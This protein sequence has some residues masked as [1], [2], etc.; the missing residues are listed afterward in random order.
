MNNQAL[1]KFLVENSIIIPTADLYGGFSG[2]QDY[3]ILGCKIKNN[4]IRIWKDILLDNNI[5]EIDT[6][7]VN[8]YDVLKASG[9]V[10]QFTDKVIFDK[11]HKCFRADHYA[12]NYFKKHNMT[13]LYA[14]VD[15]LTKQELQDLMNQ[16]KMFESDVEINDEQLMFQLKANTHHGDF[17]RPE[18]A[19][20]IIINYRNYKQFLSKDVNFGVCHIGQ[21]F[22]KEI[23]PEL[24]V[25]LRSFNQMEIEY[26]T[27]PLDKTHKNYYKYADLIIPIL[28]REMQLHNEDI[29][30]VKLDDL[31]NTAVIANELLGYF[32]AKIYLFAVEIGLNKDKLRFRQHMSNEQ[33]HYALDCWDLEVLVN[34]DWLECVG[35]AD[36]GDYDLKSHN[37]SGNYSM[38][39]CKQLDNAVEKIIIKAKI[40]ILKVKEVYGNKVGV[41]KKYVDSL[42]KSELFKIQQTFMENNNI[43]LDIDGSVY[44][45]TDK[46]V[47]ITM[48]K[49]K[50]FV[51]KF[52]PHIIE[53]SFGVDRLLYAVFEHNFWSRDLDG[54]N[55]RYVLSLNQKMAPY[56]YAVFMLQKDVKLEGVYNEVIDRMEKY[57]IPYF[58]DTSSTSIGKR[59]SRVDSMGISFALTIDYE[60]LE[61]GCVTVRN[62]DTLAQERVKLSEF[63]NMITYLWI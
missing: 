39:G 13:K 60:S 12:K 42:S 8:K 1:N 28:S 63:F 26:F 62:R 17:L 38:K 41:I 58:I 5:Y 56:K 29:V 2:F 9:H 11:E 57:K 45:L 32:L 55:T 4:F 19:Q 59:Y 47:I 10:D 53:P 6:S 31:V 3:G 51:E 46:M 44:N 23:S 48:E 30:N 35:C 24:Y 52:Y 15:S 34:N 25:R 21:S 43:D 20:S 36:R 61:D 49:V 16:Y 18:L 27:D 50:T 54:K 33:A 7:V 14:K 40:D 37:K 22:R